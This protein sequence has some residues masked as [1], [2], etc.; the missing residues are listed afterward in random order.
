[1]ALKRVL[2]GGYF[3]PFLLRRIRLDTIVISCFTHIRHQNHFS[4][5]LTKK[6]GATPH[7]H[8][9]IFKNI[10]QLQFGLLSKIKKISRAVMNISL[11]NVYLSFRSKVLVVQFLIEEGGV[12]YH[13]KKGV[14]HR[15][16]MNSLGSKGM[17]NFDPLLVPI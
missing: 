14:G 3:F 5:G 12:P 1:M 4:H 2:L 6:R 11:Y 17:V 9:K 15:F 8:L 16:L 13:I 7:F 10:L